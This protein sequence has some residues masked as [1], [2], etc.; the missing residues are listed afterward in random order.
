MTIIY[1]DDKAVPL[2]EGGGGGGGCFASD[3]LI[4]IEG[5]QKQICDI[6]VGDKVWAYDEIGQPV[7]SFV[8]ETFYH[9]K[10][11]IYRV[12]HET[13]NIDITLNHWVLKE[14][15]EYQEM[16][17]F[18]VGD[19]LLTTDNELSK[20]NSI[21]FLKEEPVYNFKVSHLH[22][23]IANGI[24]VHNGGGGGKS[25]G[26]SGTE[27]PNNLFS[28][29]VLFLQLGLGEG[30]IYRINP[31]GPQDIEF[32]EGLIDDLLIN[33]LVDDEKFFIFDNTGTVSQQPLPLFGDFILVPQRL[34]GATEL[35]KG[36]LDGVARS[37][38]DK[39][40]TSPTALTAI[41]FYFTVGGLQKQNNNGDILGSS[42]SVKAT[43][44]DRTGT[45][46]IASR[47][48]TISGKTNI[49]YSFDLFIAIPAQHVSD[50]G[51]LF[52][53]E[54]TN[55]DN[56]SS[57][58]QENVAFQG[59]TEVIET[60]IGYVRTATIGYALKAFAEH[61]GSMPA[62][63]Q[64]VKGLL[65]KVPS[66]YNQP[67]LENG[68]ID[69]REL[70][71]SDADRSTYQFRLQKTGPTLQSS[72]L[73]YDGLWDGQFVYSW[74]QNPVWV[75]YDMLTNSSYGLGIPEDH[76]DRYSFYD[77]AVYCDACDIT[78]GIFQ[79]VD[80]AAD[81]TYRN[82]PRTTKS[83]VS[84]TLQG[85]PSG[86]SIKER[87]FI[88]DGALG[89]KKQVM[90]A[91]N[92]I[93]I[94]FRAI[95]F[96][97]NGKLFL[98]QDRPDSLPVAIFNET[99]ILKD[100]FSISGIDEEEL[101]T[102]I[103]ITYTDPTNHYRQEV[104]RIDDARALDERNGIENVIDIATDGITRKSQAIRLAQY[105]IADKKYSRRKVNF[106]TTSE[107][108]EL[109]PGDVISVSQKSASV[110]WGYGGIVFEDTPSSGA[111]SSN[112]KLEHISAPSLTSTI[113]TAN[114][115]PLALR[116]AS[117]KNGHVD[118]Y[119]ISNTSYSL[120]NTANVS[121][122]TEIAEVVALS[123]WNNKNKSFDTITWDD[124]SRP[125]RYDVWSLGEIN[126]PTDIYSSLS[127]KL[128]RI[129]NLKRDKE[130]KIDVEATEY[131]PAVYTDS[132]TLINYSPLLFDDLFD[133]LK[134]PPAPNFTLEALLKRD[135]DGSI[136]NDI[137]INAITDRTGYSNEFRTEYYRARPTTDLLLI[138]NS[139]AQA[140]R[141]IVE[142]KLDNLDDVT[143]GEKATIYGKNGFTFEI[144]RSRLLVTSFDV[145]DVTPDKP[146]GNITFTTTG[147]ANL[148]DLNF[149]N[150]NGGSNVHTL[151]VTTA[152][153]FGGLKGRNRVT[154]P[155]NQKVEGGTGDSVGL[156]GF[157]GSDTRLTDYSANVQNFDSATDKIKIDNDRTGS[158]TLS[159]VLPNPPF[160]IKVPQVVDTRY[161][162][163]N[164]LYVT[165]NY[166]EVVRTNVATTSNIVGSLFKQ[167]LGVS[168]RATEFATVFI[169]NIPTD[170]FTLEKG[171]DLQANS[172]VAIT[173]STLPTSQANLDIRVVANTYSVP[174]LERGDNIIWNAGN[175][176]GIT[177]TSFDAGSEIYDAAAT[178]NGVF[179]VKLS[180]NIKANVQNAYAMNITPNPI[181]F[182]GNV[183]TIAK[184]FTLDYRSDLYP[185]LL[186][187]ANNAVYRL[188]VPIDT[189]TPLEFDPGATTRQIHRAEPGVHAVRARNVNK[190]GRRS[191]F[192]TKEVIV[193]TLPIKAV[194]NLQIAEELYKDSTVGV[195]V[196]AIVIF[197][198][199]TGQDVTDYEISYK[200]SG[201]ALGD[202][203]S[204]NTVKVSASGI[205]S[206]GKMRFKIDNLEKGL[207]TNPNKIVVRVT[208]L[209]RSI[210]GST[211]VREKTI[212]GKSAK[213]Y[214]VENFT[215]GQSGDS[216]VLGW[217]YKKDPATG[218]NID[219][220]LYKVH[221]KRIANP[222]S[223][224][225]ATLLSLWPRAERVAEKDAVTSRTTVAIDKFGTFTY[226]ARTQDT[227]LNYSDEVAITEFTTIAT[228]FADVQF[229]YSEDLP[230]AEYVVGVTNSNSTEEDYPS[231]ANSNTGGLSY[232]KAD[233]DFDASV[234][235]NSNGTSEGFS[236]RSGF[237]TDLIALGD[238]VY[239]T[240]VRDLGSSVT[241]SLTLEIDDAQFLKSTWLD[242]STQIGS[243][244]V[245]EAAT[246][247]GK[248]K[249]VDF[250]GALGIGEILGSSNTGAAT[251]T[252][253]SE[254]K[255]LVSG[256]QGSF[257][258]N[259][260][261]I[262]TTGNFLNDESNANVLSLIAGVSNDDEIVL[263]DSWYANGRSIG[264]N[265][266]SNL[267]VAGTSYKL[268]NLKQWLDLTESGTFYGT[269]GI[270]TTNSLIRTSVTDPFY[271]NGNVNV[272]VFSA[273]E[274]TTGFTSYSTGP[275]TFRY[276]QFRY[277]VNN[278]DPQQAELVL[279]Q[280]RYKVSLQTKT[281]QDTASIN[282]DSVFLDW[283]K[284]EY[285]SVPVL[286]G[287]IIASSNQRAL[288][289]MVIFDLG[290]NGAN[291]GAIF[292]SNLAS[293]H[294]ILR[295]D[296]AASDGSEDVLPSLRYS[297]TGV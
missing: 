147:V 251:V 96:Y 168:L 266:Y 28:T 220:D 179:H 282:A 122:G 252:F 69:W 160:Y 82:K 42:V 278:S 144:A 30:P 58:V 291:V 72:P 285:T 223:T 43:V 35:K 74:T 180:D 4:S 149:T 212:V 256:V 259:V 295:P 207:S 142:F 265:G 183:N 2:I 254:N 100:T 90:D 246:G 188:N 95:L 177:E 289:K 111:S 64:M 3:T 104:L 83:S 200:I 40:N 262:V 57:K 65:V 218:E 221:I 145:T 153:D 94:T 224:D 73:I 26:G 261:A 242:Y 239:Q 170:S 34:S 63:T 107:A 191:D 260:F 8:T 286:T 45:T 152:F 27:S 155:I 272:A 194:S 164:S 56:A 66:N 126:D 39:Q 15:G 287:E 210:R 204:F 19:K 85:L 284:M 129:I 6:E 217:E 163:N 44:Y 227:S 269:S 273:A 283:T 148:V 132:D 21:E 267:A 54:K 290:I 276:F 238:A 92:I 281:T 196:R 60:P 99:N 86:T 202:L 134:K 258:S 112:I 165:G 141:D 185:G 181:G 116:V 77:A 9:Q 109:K 51:Y 162:A 226:L 171:L 178:A 105:M 32:N 159:S 271:A 47:E 133:P 59:W 49:A 97:K 234:V 38:V 158:L 277:E 222:D 236:V 61:K 125:K 166:L 36:N 184:T 182:I 245:T 280:F 187:L 41:K 12:N 37:S 11:K 249:D 89:D 176:Y 250:S 140:S 93:T 225:Q 106:K 270:V 161:M 296:G 275:R 264:S 14:D 288:P 7:L 268:V 241:G 131:I 16:G 139:T 167:P 154:V 136:Y 138:S 240:Q 175:V 205:D 197:D 199:V 113:F 52:T 117:T 55:E 186:N 124:L 253:D 33:G 31:N 206:D 293:A 255:T 127:D 189:F 146:D 71:V 114:T 243:D 263:G 203:T 67:I 103:N 121:G 80:A 29:D 228:S 48:R 98:Y 193:R 62:I 195:A 201:T 81:G 279:D 50:A 247:A 76:I 257:P 215:V 70:E 137:E 68:E 143:E 157:V 88:Y 233:S 294:D 248:L 17:D 211:L 110:S 24:K 20:I 229:A 169:N 75:V 118:T 274:G 214:V 130:E 23:Y 230:G 208:P 102:G 115:G 5:G 292:S 213:P 13:G 123:K 128:F 219:L 297:V 78:T 84:E 46:A 18:V 91:V 190:F 79:G 53:V 209:N 1:I 25:G 119:V 244:A 174:I 120:S 173:L 156:S 235:D 10:D 216:L 237:A 198:H 150:A 231:F 151:D 192:V 22:S 135:L 87:R 232:S 101:I 172:Q 108:S